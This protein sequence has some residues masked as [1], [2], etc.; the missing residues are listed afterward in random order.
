MFQGI[1]QSTSSLSSSMAETDSKLTTF[2]LRRWRILAWS[3][4]LQMKDAYWTSGSFQDAVSNLLACGSKGNYQ[5]VALIPLRAPYFVRDNP[6]T[7]VVLTTVDSTEET[8]YSKLPLWRRLDPLCMRWWYYKCSRPNFSATWT[9]PV[10]TKR[11]SRSCVQQATCLCVLRKLR[12]GRSARQWLAW[13]CWSAT[14]GL[15]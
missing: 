14:Y 3:D 11:L 10:N 7:T 12:R 1:A 2:T 8:G 4:W 9:S 15:T 5:E 6:S 13:W